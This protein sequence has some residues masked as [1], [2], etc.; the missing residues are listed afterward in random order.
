MNGFLGIDLAEGM[1][2][3]AVKN[4]TGLRNAAF[5]QANAER[6]PLDN[7]TFDVAVC[8]NSFH[9]YSNPLSA[10]REVRR[11]L[12]TGGRLFIL[13]VTADDILIKIVNCVVAKKEKEHVRFYSS[14]EYR[15]MLREAGLLPLGSRLIGGYPLKAHAAGKE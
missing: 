5:Y 2:H 4:Y 8:T 10:L 7:E 3:R 12:R 6:L 11:V 9:H 15:I 13:D 14:K 1:I